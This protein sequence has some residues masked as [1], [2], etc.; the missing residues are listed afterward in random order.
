L[1]RFNELSDDWWEVDATAGCVIAE[2]SGERIRIGQTLAVTIAG[3]DI[4]GR[5]IDLATPADRKRGGRAAGG[6]GTKRKKSGG[7]RTGSRGKS[8][9]KGKPASRGKSVS[10]GKSGGGRRRRGRR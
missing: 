10:R 6:G 5:N 4:A 7:K 9:A 2:R 3:V 1:L 8:A